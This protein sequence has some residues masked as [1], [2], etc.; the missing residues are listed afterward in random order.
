MLLC[1]LTFD[2][3]QA[4]KHPKSHWLPCNIAAPYKGLHLILCI[5]FELCLLD[6]SPGV[7]CSCLGVQRKKVRRRNLN[8]LRWAPNYYVAQSHWHT[9]ASRNWKVNPR[10]SQQQR[11]LRILSSQHPTRWAP[12]LCCAISLTHSCIQKLESKATILPATT[13]AENFVKQ[14]PDEVRWSVHVPQFLWRPY[15]FSNC[16]KTHREWL[17]QKQ[18]TLWLPW[19]KF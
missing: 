13:L 18:I 11:L 7:I 16:R 1:F 12:R 19:K 3:C 2:V 17:Q 4:T 10:C 5:D 15:G 8:F 9:A 14:K 6:V